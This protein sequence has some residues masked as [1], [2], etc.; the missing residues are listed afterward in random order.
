MTATTAAMLRHQRG[1]R[2]EVRWLSTHLGSRRLFTPRLL[3]GTPAATS[4]A[5]PHDTYDDPGLRIDL[6]GRALDAL[7]DADP[8]VWRMRPGP[9]E[10]GDSDLLWCSAA[11]LAMA[12]RGWPAEF[13]VVNRFGWAELH[14]GQQ[15]T[16]TRPRRGRAA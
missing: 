4:L 2:E 13:Y 14:S 10:A 6:I 15:R 7:D 16:W 5:L 8:C 9:L 11:A 3:V 1:L 12:V